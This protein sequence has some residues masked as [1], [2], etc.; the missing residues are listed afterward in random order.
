LSISGDAAGSVSFDGSANADIA[1]TIQS[2]AVENSM[3]A[4]NSITVSDGTS[5]EPIA[6]GG[7]FEIVGTPNQ[8]NVQYATLD[9]SF[10]VS[11]PSNVSVSSNLSVGSDLEVT[12]NLSVLGNA[13]FTGNLT[14][15]SANIKLGDTMLEMGLNNEISSD[16][17][18]FSQRDA[19]SYTGIFFDET[20]D[21]W[22]VF[23]DTSKPGTTVDTVASS[24]AEA[25]MKVADF[26]AESIQVNGAYS[27][28]TADGSNGQ[29]LTTDG[30]G[31]VTFATPSAPTSNAAFTVVTGNTTITTGSEP[32]QV[33]LEN[34]NSAL[35]HTLPSAADA[36][37]GYSLTVKNGGTAGTSS[38]T[39]AGSDVIYVNTGS[40][41]NFITVAPLN[42]VRL[43]SNGVD[44]WYVIEA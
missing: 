6:L 30:S 41:P 40:S 1:L 20:D 43:M 26:K 25:N 17:G 24:Y 28:P 16:H 19:N 38:L 36:G 9:N 4:N 42:W 23:T 12:S 33:V 18:F 39:R 3:L 10:T 35:A 14:A 21:Y 22:K 13:L 8:V 34:S 29:V 7:A 2:G 32:E 37:E 31:N 27:L 11:L 44:T 15:T 5:G